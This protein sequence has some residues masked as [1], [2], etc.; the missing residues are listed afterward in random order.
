MFRPC[1]VIYRPP[2]VMNGVRKVTS[3]DE[4]SWTQDY[5]QVLVRVV[6]PSLRQRSTTTSH[7]LTSWRGCYLS[8][9][10]QVSHLWSSHSHICETKCGRFDHTF[11]FVSQVTNKTHSQLW[12]GLKKVYPQVRPPVPVPS[13]SGSQGQ[14]YDVFTTVLK[15]MKR[16][17]EQRTPKLV[18]VFFP[19]I[20]DCKRLLKVDKY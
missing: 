13:R 2:R 4:D 14:G 16:T 17:Q 20:Q 18:T 7:S 10:H 3:P 11:K 12:I 6:C 5:C 1:Q 15:S 9:S 8:V 19:H